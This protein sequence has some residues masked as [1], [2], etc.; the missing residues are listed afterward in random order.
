MVSLIGISFADSTHKCNEWVDSKKY[1][2]EY[3]H[4]KAFPCLIVAQIP[5]AH[6]VGHQLN[7]GHYH[8]LPPAADLS[9]FAAMMVFYEY[10]EFIAPKHFSRNR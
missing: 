7:A 8:K 1:L 9:P 10:F 5:Q 2:I 6:S 4:A 3:F